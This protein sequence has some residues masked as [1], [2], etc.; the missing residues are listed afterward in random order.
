MSGQAPRTN[1]IRPVW[2]LAVGLAASAAVIVWQTRRLYFFGDE[3][4]FLLDRH[5]GWEQLVLPHNEHWS[6]LP[7][8]SY[9]LMFQI[10]GIDHHLA[11]ALLP[12]LLHVGICV[13]SYA[14]M[15]RHQIGGW[16]AVLA[17]LLLAFLC[18]NLAENPLWAFQIGF[19]GSLLAGL[20]AVL[21]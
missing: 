11:Y 14:L 5:L 12:V 4:A 1:W 20:L 3:W 8:I 15:R 19:L 21:L 9:R 6:T 10:F 17:T 13:T 18:G 7:L 2:V 16:S